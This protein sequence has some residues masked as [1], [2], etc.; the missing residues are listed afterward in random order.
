M[1]I[2]KK[3]DESDELFSPK[4]ILAKY[5]GGTLA[6]I[7]VA[8]LGPVVTFVTGAAITAIVF[9]LAAADSKK[10]ENGKKE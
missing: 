3:A 10:A 9:S 7:S 5:A 2:K 1:E 6:V 4:H 8:V